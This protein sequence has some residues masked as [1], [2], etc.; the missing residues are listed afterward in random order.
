MSVFKDNKIDLKDVLEFIPEA[1]LTH[2]SAST[3]VDHYSKIVH[4]KENVL[5]TFVFA[6][7]ITKK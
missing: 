5:P 2:L 1:F 6:S 3:K 4:G 7:L